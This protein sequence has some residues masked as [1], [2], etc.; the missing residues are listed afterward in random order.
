MFS[1][2]WDVIL[3]LVFTFLLASFPL[4]V[5]FERENTYRHQLDDLYEKLE[6]LQRH[7]VVIFTTMRVPPV[8]KNLN[9]ILAVKSS[10]A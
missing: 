3:K 2:S 5:W 10:W 8:F 9:P 7:I 4:S 1:F 6:V